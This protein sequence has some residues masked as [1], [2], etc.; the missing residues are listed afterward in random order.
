MKV[1]E[2]IEKVGLKLDIQ[3]HRSKGIYNPLQKPQKMGLIFG[4]SCTLECTQ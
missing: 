4:S 3:K 2:E 1:K